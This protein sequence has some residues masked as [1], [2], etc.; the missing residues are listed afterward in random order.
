MVKAVQQSTGLDY[1]ICHGPFTTAQGSVAV[2]DVPY[3]KAHRIW[4]IPCS[5]HNIINF[6]KSVII[7]LHDILRRNCANLWTV[8]A[9]SY[10]NLNYF[11]FKHEAFKQS[12]YP[13]LTYGHRFQHNKVIVIHVRNYNNITKIFCFL[14]QLYVNFLPRVLSKPFNC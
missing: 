12:T 2:I 5:N 1:L 6:Y 7:S 4:N 3:I 9:V 10:T 14:L 13:V 11:P 8:Q